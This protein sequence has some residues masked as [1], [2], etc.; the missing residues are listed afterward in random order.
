MGLV[1]RVVPHGALAQAR[2]SSPRSIAAR[3]R[4]SRCGSARRLPSPSAALP[5]AEAYATAAAVM[6]ENLLAEDAAEGIGAF[7]GK[8]T[9]RWKDR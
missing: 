1:N 9:P 2:W 7:L 6:A 3:S 8:R 5:L 4:A